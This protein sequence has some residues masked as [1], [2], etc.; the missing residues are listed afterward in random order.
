MS[1]SPHNDGV[2]IWSKC[3][4][5]VDSC[6]REKENVDITILSVNYAFSF[7]KK[8]K[9]YLREHMTLADRNQGSRS[10]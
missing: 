4:G 7:E 9:L 8:E 10:K 2:I 3:V 5:W 6:E 1:K